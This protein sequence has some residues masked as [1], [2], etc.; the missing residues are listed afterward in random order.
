MKNLVNIVLSEGIGLYTGGF[1]VASM[2]STQG[3]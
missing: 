3:C 2:V 1:P